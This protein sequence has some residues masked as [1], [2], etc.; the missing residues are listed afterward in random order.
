MISCDRYQ[1]FHITQGV[2][3]TLTYL[4]DGSLPL[5]L[6]LWGPGD[7]VGGM[8]SSISPY[9]IECFTT[10]E[11]YYFTPDETAST[12]AWI[13]S[14]LRQIEE[15]MMIR[16]LKTSDVKLIRLLSWLSSR[17][18]HAG[19]SGQTIDLRLTHQDIAELAGITR[20]TATRTLGQLE[21]QGHIERLPL[22]RFLL[23]EAE[24]W[25]YEI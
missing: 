14:H 10:V 24:V 21:T 16:S 1:L 17:F 13:K 5:V 8:L 12:L 7:R 15:L 2:A 19:S 20:V 22:G 6:G 23:R 4:E 25:Y 3:R 18:G 11:G 9:Y